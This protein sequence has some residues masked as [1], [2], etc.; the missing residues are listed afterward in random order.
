M[1]ILHIA[2]TENADEATRERACEALEAAGVAVYRAWIERTPFDDAQED[3]PCG[4]V[5]EKWDGPYRMRDRCAAAS[6]H[7]GEHGPWEMVR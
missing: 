1:S 7:R 4:H 3:T 6:G 2:I 5:R